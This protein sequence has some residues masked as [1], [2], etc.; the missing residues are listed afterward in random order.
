MQ[1][2]LKLDT[3]IGYFLL[4]AAVAVSCSILC[5]KNMDLKKELIKNEKSIHKLILLQ[6]QVKIRLVNNTNLLDYLYMKFF[7]SSAADLKHSWELYLHERTERE[8]FEQ[9]KFDLDYYNKELFE[10]LR[11]IRV[12]D[13]YIWLHQVPALLDKKE[14]VEVRH[15][16]IVRRQQLRKQLD[17]NKEVAED[18]NSKLKEMIQLYPKYSHEILDKINKFDNLNKK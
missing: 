4:L 14:M 2:V 18:A 15:N 6:N 12:Q 17:Y 7:V 16:Y 10:L 1:F 8:R 9:T 13:P 11:R 5:L 3:Q